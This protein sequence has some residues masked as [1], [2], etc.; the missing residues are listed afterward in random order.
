MWWSLSLC[1]S[2]FLFCFNYLFLLFFIMSVCVFS[3]VLV[4]INLQK[5]ENGSKKSGD[6]LKWLLLFDLRLNSNNKTNC[7]TSLH[8]A[9]FSSLTVILFVSAERRASLKGRD[10]CYENLRQTFE[11]HKRT[12]VVQFLWMEP[13]F[14]GSRHFS[15]SSLHVFS[16]RLRLDLKWCYVITM[17]Q[18]PLWPLEGVTVASE[19]NY[20]VKL[21]LSDASLL[22]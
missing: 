7:P 19:L 5:K 21:V 17:H 10:L 15:L 4:T 20:G 3:V 14:W 12:V 22:F 8:K 11:L 2:L 13:L 1:C 16:S 9:L 6:F 18:R